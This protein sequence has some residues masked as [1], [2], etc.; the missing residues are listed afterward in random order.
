MAFALFGEATAELDITPTQY[1]LLYLLK[2]VQ[3]DEA[4]ISR[5]VGVERST[6][7]RLLGRLKTRGYVERGRQRDFPVLRL[8][9]AGEAM[10]ED[11]RRRSEAVDDGLINA[12]PESG[13]ADFIDILAKLLFVHG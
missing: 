12:L 8:T 4:T 1:G 3:T 11:V 2:V 10:F 9:P 7:D 6:S 13:R 5:L